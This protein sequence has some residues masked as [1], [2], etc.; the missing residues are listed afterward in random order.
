MTKQTVLG[1]LAVLM[2]CVI[3]AASL[4]PA[5]AKQPIA[6]YPLLAGV[7][8]FGFGMWMIPSSGAPETFTKITVWLGNSSLPIV[9]GRRASDPPALKDIEIPPHADGKP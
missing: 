8:V 2:G 9:G 7:G 5:L 4:A 6:P 1:V 3:I